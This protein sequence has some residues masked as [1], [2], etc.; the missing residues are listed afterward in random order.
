MLAVVA[1][2]LCIMCVTA[3]HAQ[4]R[5]LVDPAAAQAR[6]DAET[7]TIIVHL[8]LEGEIADKVREVL[9]TRSKKVMDLRTKMRAS[10][11]NRGDFGGMRQMIG[12]ID[13]ETN[14]ALAEL[15]SAE[16]M[17]KYA[18]FTKKQRASRQRGPRR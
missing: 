11:S 2:A 10:R 15:L 12:A 7:D 17:E 1:M 9:V 5:Q 14:K 6:L 4:N 8:G 18:E 16:Q 13:E 3:V